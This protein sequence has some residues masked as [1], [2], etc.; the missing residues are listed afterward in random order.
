MDSIE[1]IVR[2][3]IGGGRPEPGIAVA[4]LR[5]GAVEYQGCYGLADLEWGVPVA[6]DSVFALASVSKPLTALAVVL[7]RQAGLVELDA[8]IIDY[9]P[10]YPDVGKRITLKH[11]LT[12]TSGVPNYVTLPAFQGDK[13]RLDHTPDELT[14][15]FA[16]LPLDFEPGSRYTYSNSGYWLLGRILESVGG[17]PFP[18]LM[19]DLVFA[20]LGMRDARFLDAETIVPRRVHAYDE[21]DDGFVNA[22]TFSSTLTGGAGG[23]G[24]T[25]EDMVAF[26][27]AMR[28]HL[29]LD[30]GLERELYTPV[31]LTHGR[32]E[33]YGLGWMLS[34][35]HGQPTIGHA[36]G[37]PGISTFYGRLPEQDL[38]VVVLSNRGRLDAPELARRIVDE[39]LV[40]PDPRPDGRAPAALSDEWLGTYSDPTLGSAKLIAEDGHFV[41]DLWGTTHRFVPLDDVSYIADDDPG[42]VLTVHP[43]DPHPAITVNYPFGWFTGYRQ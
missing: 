13:L 21:A 24:A 34:S 39:V 27:L 7:A 12:H 20:P 37:L 2:A 14:A 25:L 40:L 19:R 8:P 43:A 15:A 22:V 18:R 4:V 3:R 42:I 16:G 33:G 23:F 32:E 35:Y 28:G 6:P 36:G 5:G 1:R 26:D 29:V 11:L 31:R 30:A 41:L 38:S 10:D 9:L 17:M